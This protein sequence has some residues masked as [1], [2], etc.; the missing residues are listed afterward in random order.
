MKVVVIMG[1]VSD[2]GHSLKITK[3]LDEYGIEWEQHAASAHKEPRKVL[4]ILDKN[5]D[6]QTREY[7]STN[8]IKQKEKKSIFQNIK[9]KL[10]A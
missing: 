5:S 1:S 4:E 10:R 8:I 9:K 2:E 7:S 6:F 3:K